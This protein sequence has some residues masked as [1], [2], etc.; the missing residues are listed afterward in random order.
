MSL[1]SNKVQGSTFLLRSVQTKIKKSQEDVADECWEVSGTIVFPSSLG[2]CV[3]YILDQLASAVTV[4]AIQCLFTV[5][6][7]ELS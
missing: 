5:H 2:S 6:S 4:S 3:P 7:E 1:N